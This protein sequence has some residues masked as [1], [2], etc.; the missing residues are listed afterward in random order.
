MVASLGSQACGVPLSGGREAMSGWWLD[1]TLIPR[2]V[3]YKLDMM[4]FKTFIV[5][6]VLIFVAIPL[7]CAAGHLIH[8][9]HCDG[10]DCDHDEKHF[11]HDPGEHVIAV[12]PNVGSTLGGAALLFVPTAASFSI[13]GLGSC[14]PKCSR[15][16][17]SM[18]GRNL[19]CPPSALPQLA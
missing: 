9:D 13:D 19:P 11:D 5:V 18:P 15:T 16:R 4:I 17:L 6:V 8:D 7:L 12:R 14:D 3:L 1:G 2:A 10:I